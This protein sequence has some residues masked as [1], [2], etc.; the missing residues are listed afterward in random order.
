[1][2]EIPVL[3]II[4]TQEIEDMDWIFLALI[5]DKWL[6]I[7]DKRIHFHISYS[8]SNF[9]TRSRSIRFQVG[10]SFLELFI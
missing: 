4:E 5:R 7:V 2:Q 10:E 6:N 8:V 3:L 1:V 9:L